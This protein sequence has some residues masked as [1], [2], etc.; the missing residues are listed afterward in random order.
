MR[1][2]TALIITLVIGGCSTM[3]AQNAE[4]DKWSPEQYY[5]EARKAQASGD[6]KAALK[7]FGELEIFYPLSPYAQLAP[8]EI[9]Y[10]HY[11]LENFDLAI[12]DS[13]RF[14]STY[15]DHANLDYAF[16]LRG[17][18]QSGLG[19]GRSTQ[20]AEQTTILD[21]NQAR[22]AFK[23]FS[24]V[25][26][27]FPESRYRDSAQQR[28]TELRNLMAMNELQGVKAKLAAGEQEAA[29]QMAKYISDQYPKTPA[30]SQ[31]FE[32]VT[33]ASSTTVTPQSKQETAA[34]AVQEAIPHTTTDAIHR[35]T[36]LLQRDPLH[37][38][39]QLIGTSD[40]DKLENY[41]Q[42]HKLTTDAAYYQR[43][44]NGKEWYS[45]LYGNYDN[46]ADARSTAATLKTKLGLENIWVRQFGDIQAQLAKTPTNN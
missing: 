4:Q 5:T 45:L 1:L 3:P 39:L 25:M 36:W 10:A 15:P 7:Y 44:L 6:H 32:L 34:A 35:E 22:E 24:T 37:F 29:L 16:Y 33:Q 43:L 14:I 19:L 27:R 38:T 8:V 41:I 18:A 17:L 21:N 11:K 26:Q 12:K 23:S 46:K 13:Q 42:K 30:A 31:A 9:A 2:L 40:R 28:M 20:S